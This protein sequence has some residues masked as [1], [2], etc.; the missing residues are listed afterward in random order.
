MSDL[1]ISYKREEQ[2]AAKRLA[3]ALERQGWSVWWDPQLRVGEHFDDVIEDAL[4]DAKCVIVLWS[5]QS[6]DS[7]YV[8]DEAT[9]ALNKEKLIPVAIEDVNLPFRFSGLQT[10][11]LHGWDG[12][13]TFPGFL[14]LVADIKSII[15][16]PA[17]GTEEVKS[18]PREG[19]KKVEAEPRRK[20]ISSKQTTGRTKAEWLMNIVVTVALGLFYLTAVTTACS[21]DDILALSALVGFPISIFLIFQKR[22]YRIAWLFVPLISFFIGKPYGHN[23]G[24]MTKSPLFGLEQGTNCQPSFEVLIV[25]G[26]VAV[27]AVIDHLVFLHTSK[28]R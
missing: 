3:F 10:A 9:Y 13:D 8:R 28:K 7:R 22:P 20:P 16:S 4:Q 18:V 15:G 23:Y 21:N 14:K 12:S 26:V 5:K 1:F 17:T 6:V 19:L 27:A 24:T 2:P 25:L 11:Q